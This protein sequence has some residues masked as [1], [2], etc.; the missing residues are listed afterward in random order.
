MD[1]ISKQYQQHEQYEQSKQQPERY[2]RYR[3]RYQRYQAGK[4]PLSGMY[5]GSSYGGGAPWES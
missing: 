2:Q 1:T 3:S 5:N 4:Y